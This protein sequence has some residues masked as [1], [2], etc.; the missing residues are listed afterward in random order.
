VPSTEA[1]GSP[2]E[3]PPATAPPETAPPVT[4]A[5]TTAP[6]SPGTTT[7]GSGGCSASDVSG[8]FGQL[9]NAITSAV[10]TA[11]NWMVGQLVAALNVGWGILRDIWGLLYDLLGAI[12]NVLSSLW[13]MIYASLG[14]LGGVM[15]GVGADV[16]EAGLA[17]VQAV[18]GVAGAI[19]TE[20]QYLLIPTQAEVEPSLSSLQST[21]NATTPGVAL[22]D[23]GDVVDVVP[24]AVG[25][26]TGS[27]CG[28]T[29]GW[30]SGNTVGGLAIPAYGVV[31]PGPSPCAGNGAGGSRTTGDNEVATM[32]GYRTVVRGVA[33]G[34][35][36]VYFL[37]WVVCSLP[38]MHIGEFFAWD[39]DWYKMNVEQP[40]LPGF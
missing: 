35:M 29:V 23:L 22:A 26:L 31:L 14:W 13:V 40:T 30:S 24:T 11:I 39:G 9:G 28:P 37:W 18:E 19:S 33:E 4:T 17:V 1:A 34:M 8:C 36:V 7:T 27:A 3:A 16:Y 6:P 25:T 5:T 20:L 21:W 12:Y 38:W 15:Q 10:Q 32:F 2:T